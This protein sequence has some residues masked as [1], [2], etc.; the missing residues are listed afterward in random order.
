MIFVIY[1][2]LSGL[3]LIG[4]EIVEKGDTVSLHYTGTLDSGEEFDSSEG[5]SPFGFT[6]GSGDVIAGF[7]KAVLGMKIGEEKDFRIPPEE[8]YGTD[9]NLHPLGGQALNF[10]I[11]IVD[12]QKS[13]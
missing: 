13:G 3:S 5:R 1:M 12:I 2:V 7:D 11:R 8:A 9:P 10:H 6:A 4:S